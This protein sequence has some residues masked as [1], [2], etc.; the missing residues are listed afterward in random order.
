MNDQWR[1]VVRIALRGGNDPDDHHVLLSDLGEL[2]TYQRL[3]TE[4]ARALFLQEHPQRQRVLKGFEGQLQLGFRN[5]EEG[6]AV[7]PLEVR[8]QAQPLFPEVQ[9]ESYVDRAVTATS[10]VYRRAASGQRADGLPASV[11]TLMEQFGSSL[12][13][14]RFLEIRPVMASN[15]VAVV[16]AAT[17][18]AVGALVPGRLEDETRVEGTVTRADVSAKRFRLTVGRRG[19]EAPFSPEDKNRVIDALRDSDERRVIVRG[20]ALLE[21]GGIPVRF[22]TVEEIAFV[23]DRA[24]GIAEGWASLIGF[25]RNRA[26]HGLPADLASSVDD[27]LYGEHSE[28]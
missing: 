8:E 28:Q 13:D 1:T 12:P 21:P 7:L 3:I 19:I 26:V 24:G 25:G 17:R 18:A 4:A 22:L 23:D 2:E 14:D 9:V 15:E 10:R 16:D 5:V 11:L 27:Y 6:S 20:R